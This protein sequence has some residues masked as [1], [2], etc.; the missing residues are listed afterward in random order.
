MSETEGIADQIT[1]AIHGDAWYGD[2][3]IALLKGISAEQAAGRPIT[4][5]HT[6]WEIL[7]HITVWVNIISRRLHGEPADATPE[8]DWPT[9]TDTSA[10][11]WTDAVSACVVAHD[12]LAHEVRQL[13]L[14]RLEDDMAGHP[15]KLYSQLHG[16]VQHTLYHTG[17]ISIL[18][19]TVSNH[20]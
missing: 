19:K 3:L 20:L 17:Q 11:A 16:I 8:E 13:P 9:L 15:S 12:Q 1:R 6:I 10:Q 7:A 4:D 18:K 14:S 2:G 5:A